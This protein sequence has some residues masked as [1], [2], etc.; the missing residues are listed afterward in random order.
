MA[1]FQSLA[2]VPTSI[3]GCSLWLDAADSRTITTSGTTVTAWRDKSGQANNAIFS[4]S[5]PTYVP[6]NRF[7]ESS[8]LNQYFTVPGTILNTTAGSIFFVFADK[9][10]NPTNGVIFGGDSNYLSN[11]FYAQSGLRNDGASYALTGVNVPPSGF[12]TQINTTNTILY[13][14]NYIYNSSNLSAG[15]NGTLYSMTSVFGNQVVTPSGAVGISGT[16]WGGRVNL[17]MN[18][19]LFFNSILTSLQRQ[20]LE[21]YLAWKW[22][23]QGSLP[24]TH[25]YKL[26]APNSLGLA[27]PSQLSIPLAPQAFLPIS[28]PLVFFNPTSISGCQFWL[29][30]ADPTSFTTSNTSITSWRDKSSSGLNLNVAKSSL[31]VVGTSM[32]SLNTIYF[33]SNAGLA[34]TTRLDGVKNLFW[35]GRQGSN[36]DSNDFIYLM[37]DDANF[38]WTGTT[39]NY[40]DTSFSETG[41]R[42]ATP[43][44]LFA[45]NTS[46]TSTFSAITVPAVGS[47]FFLSVAGITGSTRFQGICYD[48]NIFQRGFV[49]DIGEVICYMTALTTA[50]KQQVE[51]YLAWKWGLQGSL[52]A[53]HPYK[54]LV[55]GLNLNI[56]VPLNQF[57][58]ATFSP[59]R[60]STLTTW[61]DATDP[62]GTGVLPSNNA[63]LG[64]WI[65]KSGSGNNAS[66]YATG[67][68]FQTGVLNGNPGLLFNGSNAMSLGKIATGTNFSTFIVGRYTST[69]GTIIMFGCWKVQYSSHITFSYNLTAVAG[70]AATGPYSAFGINA[71]SST[72]SQIVASV[73]SSDTV[74]TSGTLT[75][76][77]NG[78]ANQYASAGGP[79]TNACAQNLTVGGITETDT[80]LYGM[81][82]YIHEILF[83]RSVVSTAQR[84]SIEGYLAW[85]W[86]LVA[87]LPTNHPFKRFPPPP[88]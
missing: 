63:T 14:Q 21:G 8:G 62:N 54:S 28:N 56:P 78:S 79:N 25:P 29:D 70:I 66:A 24:S 88:N 68:Q 57:Q 37:G 77:V 71:V 74:S 67:P 53:S 10:Q 42:A 51:G 19:I 34:Q 52:P 87:N 30:A 6:S 43:A 47:T 40:I 45:N 4:G 12:L 31:P 82:G 2:F 76:S 5:N 18:E 17:K 49:G 3:S 35:V 27:Y 75:T 50:Q 23:L 55:P 16:S 84:Q 36:P 33:A 80:Q 61:L 69:S 13:N 83:Y 38:D 44:I 59:A 11:N 15:I 41:L 85:K 58:P 20:Q 65:D 39:S 86:G 73:L 9:Q 60:V 26:I 7:V 1:S 64:S 32:N 81:I 22:G 48:R 46:V 72:N